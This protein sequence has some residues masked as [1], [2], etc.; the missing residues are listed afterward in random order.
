MLYLEGYTE[1]VIFLGYLYTD[2]TV[3]V[4][5]IKRENS[6]D[7]L[8]FVFDTTPSIAAVLSLVRQSGASCRPLLA[9]TGISCV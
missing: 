3:H 8:A 6:F 9:L 7:L 2:Q 4:N 5:Q 1:V